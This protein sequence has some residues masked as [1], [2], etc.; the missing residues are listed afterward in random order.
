MYCVTANLFHGQIGP[1]KQTLTVNLQGT[2]IYVKFITMISQEMEAVLKMFLDILDLIS[3][4]TPIIEGLR[5][6][7]D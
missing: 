3:F 4:S 2:L 5:G 6:K 1:A 7:V